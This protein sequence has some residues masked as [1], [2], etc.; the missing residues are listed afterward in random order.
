MSE[1]F[2]PNVGLSNLTIVLF[3]AIAGISALFVVG[4]IV[5]IISP[6]WALDLG[7]GDVLPF[8]FMLIG[9]L[10]LVE[11]PLRIALIVVFL[12]WLHR[13]YSNLSPLKARSLQSSPGWAVGWWF[14]PFA[15][16]VKPFQV[17][18]ELY[19]ESD[20]DFDPDSEFLHVPAGTPLK[21]GVWWAAFLISG[22]AARLA[23][24]LYGNGDLPAS[25]SFAFVLLIAALFSTGAA[26]LGAYIVRMV[27]VRQQA[28]FE[29]VS[30][31]ASQINEPPPPPKFE[32]PSSSFGSGPDPTGSVA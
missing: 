18:R 6:D 5:S 17:V 29:V 10:A 30:R 25:D 14:I 28:R 15:N 9:L 32:I 19:N 31:S 23:D 13:A 4:A 24:L 21:I 8:G 26:L 22:F 7:D 11:L 2:K 1:D 12:I 20:P 3:V 16:L 27:N